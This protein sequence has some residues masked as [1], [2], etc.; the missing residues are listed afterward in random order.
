MRMKT[1][2][3]PGELVREDCLMPLGLSVTAAAKWLGISRNTMSEIV[4][5][6]AGISAEMAL[7]LEKAGWSTA[8]AWVGMQADYDLAQAKRRESEIKVKRYPQ[9]EPA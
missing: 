7:R 5:G 4:N 8:E 2:P 6:R 3:H 1:P 9:P